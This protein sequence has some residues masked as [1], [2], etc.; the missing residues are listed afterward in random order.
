MRQMRDP[1]D[2]DEDEAVYFRTE[3]IRLDDN[4]EPIRK[5]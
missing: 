2:D 4:M 1:D 3:K 5:R